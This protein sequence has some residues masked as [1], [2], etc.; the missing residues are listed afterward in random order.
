MLKLYDVLEIKQPRKCYKLI[1]NNRMVTNILNYE[2]AAWGYIYIDMIIH[3]ILK[4]DVGF[5]YITF[6]ETVVV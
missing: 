4:T 3:F 6:R 2:K 1:H 5:I